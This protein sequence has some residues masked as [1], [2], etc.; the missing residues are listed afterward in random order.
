MD[1]AF[2]P[3]L[4]LAVSRESVLRGRGNRGLKQ[5]RF[6]MHRVI[7]LLPPIVPSNSKKFKCLAGIVFTIVQTR[8]TE[9]FS[10]PVP[11][12]TSEIQTPRK[13]RPFRRA[14]GFD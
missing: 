5:D 14:K 8:W 1:L 10:F 12:Q 9:S 2:V 4:N 3:T 7:N 6:D 11:F 13:G